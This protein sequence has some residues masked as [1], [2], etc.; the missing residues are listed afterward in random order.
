VVAVINARAI[1]LLDAIRTVALVVMAKLVAARA[2]FVGGADWHAVRSHTHLL[3]LD[4]IAIAEA[5]DALT[6]ISIADR[7]RSAVA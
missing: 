5:F 3:V 1:L 4:A 6:R 7:T 2:V